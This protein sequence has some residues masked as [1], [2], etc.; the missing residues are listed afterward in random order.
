MITEKELLE[1]LKISRTTLWR[2]RKMGMPHIKVGSTY[3]YEKEDVVRWLKNSNALLEKIGYK[4]IQIDYSSTLEASEAINILSENF[5][6]E[7]MWAEITGENIITLYINQVDFN[8]LKNLESGNKVISKI[9]EAIE[10]IRSY[11]IKG[12]KRIFVGYDSEKKVVNRKQKERERGKYFYAQD[13][14]YIKQNNQL[15]DE[16]IDKIICGDSEEV[17]K[18]L[19]DNCIDLIFTSPPYNFGLEYDA[20]KDG[21][22]WDDYFDKLF[23]IFDECI[24][25]LKYGGRIIV[26]IQPLFSDY[27]PTHHIISNFFMERKLIWKGEVIWEKNNYNCKY[28]AW[29]S[30]KS[31]SNPYLKYTWEFLEIFCKGTL[32]K[33]GSKDNIDISAD[34]F[35][36]WVV[37]KWAIAPEKDMAKYGHPAMFPEE[38]AKRVIKL[39]S[40]KNDVILDPFN[41]VGTTTA[42]AK[43]LGRKF[44]GID[45]S[46]E[47]CEKALN[48]V[49]QITLP[50]TSN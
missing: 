39:F 38:L 4:E 20:Q 23:K 32:K 46:K 14:E 33:E 10:S 31:P 40:Y 22:F 49:N 3:R 41:G 16:F 34:E 47:Y 9:I 19:P 25:V 44:L 17:L 11:G 18:G 15:P 12:G 13:H 26:N 42:V 2:L 28:T 5:K 37:A 8:K 21:Y 50:C 7:D 36:E 43:K 30:W 24:R 1:E 6:K 35:K 27:I 48:R 45:I 29:G